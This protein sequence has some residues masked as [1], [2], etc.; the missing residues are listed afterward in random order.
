V[1][2]L[3]FTVALVAMALDVPRHDRPRSCFDTDN[4]TIV[5]C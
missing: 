1:L 4:L 5:S 3:I 2:S